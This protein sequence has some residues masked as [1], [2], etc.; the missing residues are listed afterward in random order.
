MP[1]NVIKRR[2]V[3]KAA[4]V[5]L[6]TV[7]HALNHKLGTRV[8]PDTRARIKK[9]AKEMGYRPNFVGRALV[10]GKSFTAGLM[11]PGYEAMLRLFYQRI[12]YGAVTAMNKD[13]YNLLLTFRDNAYSYLRNINQGRVD[14]I[15]VLQSDFDDIHINKIIDT[16]IPTVVVNRTQHF[17]PGSNG[18]CVASDHSKVIREIMSGMA[19]QGCRSII[20]INDYDSCD[21][22]RRLGDA[23]VV[24]ADELRDKGVTVERL[25]PSLASFPT[26]MLEMFKSKP[27][28]DAIYIDGEI[29]IEPLAK[30]AR[31][32]GLK[33]GEDFLLAVT[34]AY[35]EK[36]SYSAPVTF[37][38]QQPE[39]TGE[40]A[41]QM[42][43]KKIAGEPV[44]ELTLIPYK[45]QNPR[46]KART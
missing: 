45:K 28:P 30:A 29:M 41:W 26:Q 35:K 22:N 13:D 43:K 9:I 6:T 27:C 19:K 25:I 15:I 1:K 38:E 5:S 36:S 3:A 39:L 21:P 8:N 16:D 7:T 32:A 11:Q 14:G 42:M 12:I 40:T 17:E 34:D 20:A 18:C 44:P 4:G 46:V 2:D 24:M 37:Y 31:R 10:T 33:P 23:C